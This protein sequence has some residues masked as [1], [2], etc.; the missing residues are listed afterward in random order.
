MKSLMA[1]LMITALMFGAPVMAEEGDMM[2]DM[3]KSTEEM[4]THAFSYLGGIAMY[5]IH[6][7]EKAVRTILYMDHE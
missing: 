4:G 2:G 1:L 3:A 5:P 6:I 7:T